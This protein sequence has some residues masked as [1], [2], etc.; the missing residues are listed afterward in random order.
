[1]IGRATPGRSEPLLTIFEAIENG[2]WPNQRVVY[3]TD[4]EQAFA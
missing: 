3:R 4:C 1:M 2:G